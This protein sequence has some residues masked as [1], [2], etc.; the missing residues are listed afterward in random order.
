[1]LRRL[2]LVFVGAAAGLGAWTACTGDGPAATATGG[3]GQPCN[4]GNTCNAPE[5]ACVSNVCTSASSTTSSTSSSS[6]GTTSSSS[7]APPPECRDLTEVS[8]ADPVLCPIGPS[9]LV[10][11]KV[12]EI[13]CP[14]HGG[15][16]TAEKCGGPNGDDDWQCLARSNCKAGSQ[17]YVRSSDFVPDAGTTCGVPLRIGFQED[18]FESVAQCLGGN[19]SS[20]WV[21]LCATAE[22]CENPADCL[23]AVLEV[24]GAKMI[25]K[26]C[27]ER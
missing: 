27:R 14:G 13:C 24:A 19:P 2:A 4:P 23:P 5:L 16:K 1:M 26:A 17:C 11:C 15:C 18:E 9:Q 12:G 25:V 20:P 21:Q 3:T 7:G 6:S 22:E 8:S 10:T